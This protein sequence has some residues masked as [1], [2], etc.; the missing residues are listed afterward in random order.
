MKIKLSNLVTANEG[1]EM[2]MAPL[3]DV[4]FLLLIFFMVTSSLQKFETDLGIR[5]PGRIQQ[6]EQLVMPD[7]QIVEI[8]PDGRVMLNNQFYDAPESREMPQLTMTL[9]RFKQAS[10][11][12]NVRALLTIQASGRSEHQRLM[13]VLNAAAGADIAFVSIGLGDAEDEL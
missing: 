11:L 9:K 8:L 1:D 12:A 10:D 5:L 3:I 4:V 2:Q 13:D 7:E 6:S